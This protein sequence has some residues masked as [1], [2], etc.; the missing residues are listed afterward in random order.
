ME[1]G[2][3]MN[4]R[5]FIGGALAATILPISSPAI[6]PFFSK[7]ERDFIESLAEIILPGLNLDETT[8]LLDIFFT[9]SP[10]ERSR[11]RAGLHMLKKRLPPVF[12][13]LSAEERA[14]RLHKVLKTRLAGNA[15]FAYDAIRRVALLELFSRQAG[16]DFLATPF[17][18]S[19]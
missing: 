15:A 10:A 17:R 19:P 14:A 12:P 8:R 11:F 4:R 2:D 1:G 16:R 6:G 3:R 18:T 9:D 13:A 7:P 5:R